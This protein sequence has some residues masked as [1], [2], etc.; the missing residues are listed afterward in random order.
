MVIRRFLGPFAVCG[1]LGFIPAQALLAN[2]EFA[3]NEEDIPIVLSASR[4]RQPI[5]ESP[6]SITVI[7]R[8]MIEQSGARSIVDILLL[9]PGFQVGRRLKG[10]PVATYHG[11][12]ERYNPR[13]QLLVDGRPTFVPLFGGIPWGELPIALTDIER[14]EVTRAPN[15]ATFGP[16]SFAAVVSITTRSPASD[17]GCWRSISEAGG[18]KY[19]SGTLTYFGSSGSFDY[20][21]TMQAEND[22]GYKNIPDRERGRLASFRSFWQVNS[23]DRIGFDSGILRAGHIELSPLQMP[24]LLAP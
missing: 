16:N 21:F 23:T 20:R 15:A 22:E 14:V 13:L 2:H 18:N 1:F 19:S 5:S 3:L 10:N 4:L 24:E 8:Q 7:D 17:S 6:A 12:A 9:V 11:L